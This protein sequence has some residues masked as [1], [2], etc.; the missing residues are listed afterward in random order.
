MKGFV[1]IVFFLLFGQYCV[2]QWNSSLQR[3]HSHNDY[4]QSKPFHLAYSKGFGSIEAD[5]HLKDG[6]LLVGHNAEDLTST[7]SLESLY[8]IPLN[9]IINSNDSHTPYNDAYKKIQLLI[10]IK[11]S[12]NATLDILI[13]VLSKYPAIIEN[14]LVTICISGNRPDADKILVY[15][16]YIKFDGRPYEVYTEAQWKRI[17]MISDNYSNYIKLSKETPQQ[18]QIDSA[19]IRKSIQLAHTHLKPFR[20][21][22]NPD[23]EDNWKF[24]WNE[25]VDFINTDQV[26]SLS[27]FLNK[28]VEKINVDN[29]Q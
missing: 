20:F 12:A 25:Q 27:I 18:F 6:I 9:Q 5:I 17:G 28:P 26:E 2:G 24:L 11:S 7:R 15:P 10:D 8:L 21:W 3:A 29:L 4:E 13:Q 19:K 22:G 16:D 23:N 1:G 14:P